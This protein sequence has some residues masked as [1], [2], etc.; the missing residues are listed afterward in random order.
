MGGAITLGL[1]PSVGA[2]GGP[3][4]QRPPQTCGTNHVYWMGPLPPCQL[5]GTPSILCSPSLRPARL[6][7]PGQCEEGLTFPSQ[8]GLIWKDPGLQSCRQAPKACPGSVLLMGRVIFR[9]QHCRRWNCPQLW[10][11]IRVPTQGAHWPPLRAALS[12]ALGVH[13]SQKS[14]ESFPSAAS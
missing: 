8:A 2:G 6:G 13:T 10:C 1:V 9:W 3:K 7:T 5:L 12:R 14:S 4:G 11:L